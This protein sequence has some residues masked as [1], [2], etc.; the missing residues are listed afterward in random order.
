MKLIVDEVAQGG[1]L[2]FSE[3][4]DMIKALILIIDDDVIE[5]KIY[6]RDEPRGTEGSSQL[7]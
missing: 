3:K 1:I 7:G 2:E 4:E 6:K 5:V